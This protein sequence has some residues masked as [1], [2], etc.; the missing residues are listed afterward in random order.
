MSA[1]ESRRARADAGGTQLFVRA[2][3]TLE[4][5]PVFTGAPRGPFVSP[6]GL[7]IGFIDGGVLK[8]VPMTGGPAVPLAGTDAPTPLGA[9][10]GP[11]DTVI[12]ATTNGATGLQQVAAA[13]RAD[14]GPH[15][16]R[17]A[18]RAKPI[19]SGRNGCRAVGPC[20]SRSRR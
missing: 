7:W 10:W 15:A 20:C 19:T 1:T 13:R 9:T 2:L 14:D 12:F 4:P 3:D 16:A 5:V 18:H 11:D 17:L 8:K 6:D